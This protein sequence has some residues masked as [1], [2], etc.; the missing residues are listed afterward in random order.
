[1]QISVKSFNKLYSNNWK[2][3]ILLWIDRPVKGYKNVYNLIMFI[4][5]DSI[6]EYGLEQQAL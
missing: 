5:L 3:V 1:M 6:R 2:Q 4:V